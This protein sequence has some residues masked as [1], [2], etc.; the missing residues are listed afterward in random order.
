[1]S[2]DVDASARRTAVLQ[3]LVG[4]AIIGSNGLM[5]RFA[6]TAPTVSAF[7]RM[8]LAGIL[9]ALLVQFRHGWQP[10]SRRAWL[11]IIV[12]ALA[13]AAD[14][15]MWH[16]SI[17][18]VGPGLSTLLANAQVFFMAL[19]GLL[20]FGEKLGPRFIAGVL[21]AFAGL[22]LLLGGDWATL[23]AEYRWGVWLGLGTGVAYAVY[24]I[25]LKRSQA[26]AALT[27]KRP[28]VEQVLCLAAFG[29]A[30]VLGLVA[31]GEGSDL[32]IPSWHSFWILLALA[33]IGHCLS[34]V[35]ISRS[36]SQ[37]SV[38]MVGLLLLFQPTVAYLLDVL[39]LGIDTSPRQWAGLGVTLLGIFVAGLKS[40]PRRGA[41]V[42]RR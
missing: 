39:V 27:S 3:L 21:L 40:L 28:P 19:A 1:M 8:F 25:G 34:W 32:R 22:W 6:G 10:L 14:L 26:E 2:R 16:R 29:S 24:N 36:L 7:W 31:W 5:V 17:L 11:W 30:L 23:P 20:F 9:L 42:P 38:A 13:F 12:P 4:A 18:I 33:G 41:T 37:L 15:W 35:L